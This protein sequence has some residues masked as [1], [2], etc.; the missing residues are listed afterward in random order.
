VLIGGWTG[1][2]VGLGVALLARGVLGRLEPASARRRRLEVIRAAPIVSDLL[3]ASLG[4]GV[5]LEQAVPV[6]ARALGGDVGQ[7]LQRVHRRVELGEPSDLAWAELAD[8]PGLGVIARAVARSARTGA[9]LARVLST[10][11]AELRA[12]ATAAA[13]A[14]VRATAVRAVLPLGLCLL[15]AF[16]LLGIVP[17]VGGLLPTP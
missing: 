8:V 16:V 10:A 5:P 4:A 17:V 7:A 9:P 12:A 13:M 11:S 6:I 14:Q 1:V 15:P 3:A 2:A